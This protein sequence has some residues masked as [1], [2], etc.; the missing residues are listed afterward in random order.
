MI[1]RI[2]ADEPEEEGSEEEAGDG[3]TAAA[4]EPAA[5]K[6]DTADDSLPKVSQPPTQENSDDQPGIADASLDFKGIGG[7]EKTKKVDSGDS[8]LGDFLKGLGQK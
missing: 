8:A 4:D 3:Q 7:G 5:Q 1:H 6:A 2:R